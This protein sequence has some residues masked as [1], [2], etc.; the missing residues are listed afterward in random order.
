MIWLKNKLS[1]P[2]NDCFITR[3]PSGYAKPFSDAFYKDLYELFGSDFYIACSIFGTSVGDMQATIYLEK[4][5]LVW[6]IE[7]SEEYE[8]W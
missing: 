7:E 8:D 3:R 6:E 4:D 5:G 1:S 2:Y